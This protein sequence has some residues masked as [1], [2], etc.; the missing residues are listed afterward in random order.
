MFLLNSLSLFIDPKRRI[1]TILSG[2]VGNV[3]ILVK[4]VLGSLYTI[5][6][7][8]VRVDLKF[9]DIYASFVLSNYTYLYL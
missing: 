3:M 4:Y 5:S 6:G 1:G 2:G 7:K 8:Y 9:I